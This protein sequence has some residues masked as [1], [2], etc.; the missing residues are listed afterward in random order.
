MQKYSTKNTVLFVLVMV[1]SFGVWLSFKFSHSEKK[2]EK[3]E[4]TEKVSENEEIEKASSDIVQKMN[5]YASCFNR[6]HAR[7]N[8]SYNRYLSWVD[9]DKGPV[10]KEQNV[11][12]L[13]TIYGSEYYCDKM[14]EALKMKPSTPTLDEKVKK[15]VKEMEGLHILLQRADKYYDHKDYLDDNFAG[16]REMHPIIMAAFQEYFDASDAFAKEYERNMENNEAIW[17]VNTKNIIKTAMKLHKS[18]QS[19][20]LNKEEFAALVKK[21]GEAV[22]EIELEKPE[23]VKKS[24][25]FMGNANEFLK[26]SKGLN[27]DLQAGKNQDKYQFQNWK[28]VY[29]AMIESYN[30]IDDKHLKLL[31]IYDK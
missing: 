16:G 21:Y 20:T 5:K 14:E 30:S 31:E 3:T 27:R 11:Y 25:S 29:S 8:D 26:L 13:Y 1:I 18:M 15:Y 2:E 24:S 17:E 12:G 6:N 23:F 7:A 22:E 28:R 10:S 19:P 4:V 9:K